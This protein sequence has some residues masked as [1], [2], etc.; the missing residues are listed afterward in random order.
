[1]SHIEWTN[2]TWNPTTGCTKVST[3]CKFCYAEKETERLKFNPN[4]Q[5]Y[6][7]GFKKV[8]LHH[9]ALKT[10]YN[11]TKPLTIFVNSMSD[12]FHED[13][14]LQF[15]KDVF[16]V[17]NN[18]PWLTY[19]ILTK[20]QDLLK[21]Y[22]NQL[23]WTDNIWMGVSV[24]I[25]E[26]VKRIQPLINCGAKHKF[27]SIEPLIEE[28]GDLDLKGID[29]LI[30][31]GESGINK[32][33]PLK[34]EWV[35]KIQK[36][37]LDQN[38]PFFFKQWGKTR[39]NPNPNDPTMN[40]THR[41]YAKGGCELDGKIYRANPT[42]NNNTI[43]SINMFDKDYLVM[44]EYE[45]LNTIWELK[46][47]LPA[48]EE[49]LYESIKDDIKKNGLKDPIKYIITPNGQK[50]VVDGHTRLRALIAL[51]KKEVYATELKET[52]D[53]ID[54]IKLWMM[55]NQSRR[56]NLS[57]IQRIRLAYS[58]KHLIEKLA[59]ENLSKAGKAFSKNSNKGKNTG[60]LK[61]NTN[62]EIAKIANVSESLIKN[63][64][65][66]LNK[67]SQTII[68]QLHNEK[69]SI[70]KALSL[71]KNT[72]EEIIENTGEKFTSILPIRKMRQSVI[73]EKL[74]LNIPI[75][76]VEPILSD[77]KEILKDS[78]QISIK[79][80]SISTPI[81]NN[82]IINLKNVSE[83]ERKLLNNEIDTIM[84]FNQNDPLKIL[85]NNPNI[86]IGVYFWHSS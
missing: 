41:Y 55:K 17:M 3:E 56:R 26:S 57:T 33:R 50:L 11:W 69:I 6:H 20:R 59:K 76:N 15:I 73:D 52:F 48:I 83:G 23:N 32:V 51:K 68:D 22:S 63:Y 4:S 9:N 31:G 74:K 70:G 14:P 60:I 30:V 66:V 34:K 77:I 10:P 43:P 45:D 82:N 46:T 72:H 78:K 81:E 67:G 24:G 75:E 21:L 53:S 27:L 25:E 38:V 44:D 16:Q 18:T 79:A 39:N 65:Q 1:M 47:Y 36:Q 62:E 12:L 58:T 80:K 35:L 5:K 61:I 2:K 86:R 40:K 84:I 13:I 85:E 19:Q 49:D 37:C 64:S 42:L 54:E 8:V 7:Q 28:L 71:L 29:W